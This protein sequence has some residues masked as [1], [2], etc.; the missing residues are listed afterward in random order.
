MTKATFTTNFAYFILKYPYN[1]NRI[2]IAFG[3]I[4]NIC[5]NRPYPEPEI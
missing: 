1:K 5:Y 3:Y 2:H 4:K